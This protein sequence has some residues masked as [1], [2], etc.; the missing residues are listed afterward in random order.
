MLFVLG[1]IVIL[2]YVIRKAIKKGFSDDM[3]LFIA[4]GGVMLCLPIACGISTNGM[5][6][7]DLAYIQ[8]IEESLPEIKKDHEYFTEMYLKQSNE[9]CHTGYC[10]TEVH[11]MIKN[12]TERF[13]EV[14]LRL[15]HHKA[16]FNERLTTAKLNKKK[17]S[18]WLFGDSMF[19]GDEF[20]SLENL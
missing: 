8:T 2:I 16:K 17:I 15:Q 14:V 11:T 4:V 19:S 1:G 6:K 18:S 7:A 5:L 20:M 12:L 3:I 9:V 13:S 10:K